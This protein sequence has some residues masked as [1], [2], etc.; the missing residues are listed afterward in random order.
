MK[1]ENK[2]EEMPRILG[3][4]KISSQKTARHFSR[5]NSGWQPKVFM[6]TFGWPLV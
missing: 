3:G 4:G 5:Q 6:K 2:I 1:A